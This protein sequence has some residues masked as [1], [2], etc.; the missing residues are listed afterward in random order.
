MEDS[1]PPGQQSRRGHRPGAIW[2]GV[3]GVV[4]G[5]GAVIIANQTKLTA[6]SLLTGGAY[7]KDGYRLA[8]QYGGI[9]LV[10]LGALLTLLASLTNSDDAAV[11]TL[12]AI[13]LLLGLLVG[14]GGG[15]VLSA[16]ENAKD[17]QQAQS[18]PGFTDAPATT[19]GTA[20]TDTTISTDTTTTTAPTTDN[21]PPI[22][23]CTLDNAGAATDQ[24][25]NVAGPYGDGTPTTRPNGYNNEAGCTW[26]DLGQNALHVVEVYA[27]R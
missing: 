24:C 20:T 19:T 17:Q 21:G 16:Y 15:L 6:T 9:A 3:V 22:V 18:S 8:L 27:C 1:S 23:N 14:L 12:R 13:T 7:V 4:V 26:H 2:L 25:T 11:N 5:I 10:A